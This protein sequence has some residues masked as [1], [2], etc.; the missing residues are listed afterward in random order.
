MSVFRLLATMGL[1]L[2]AVSQVAATDDTM[3]V[4]RRH[5]IHSTLMDEDREYWISLPS[6][7]SDSPDSYRTY[8]VLY[9]TDGEAYLPSVS[10]IV[11]FLS[12]ESVYTFQIPELIIVGLSHP[13]RVR[14]L[15]PTHSLMGQNGQENARFG[16]SGGG[17]LFLEF[18]HEELIPHIDETYRTQPFRILMG[19]SSGGLLA[20]HDLVSDRR[21]FSAHIAIDPSLW[22]D[23]RAT[24]RQAR[25]L[26]ESGWDRHAVVHLSAAAPRPVEGYDVQ[27]HFDAIKDFAGLLADG[28]E[29]QFVSRYEYFPEEEHDTVALPGFSQGLKFV[30]EGY[31]P[32]FYGFMD[33]PSAMATQ[34]EILTRRLGYTMLPPE[35]MVNMLGQLA[36]GGGD[37]EGA[38]VFFRI[39][40]SNY[41]DSFH[42]VEALVGAL[43]ES[44]EAVAEVEL[45]LAHNP[46][47][48]E[49]R[50]LLE[51]MQPGD[52]QGETTV[53]SMDE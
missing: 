51:E 45:F 23:D 38:L 33:N 10:G 8:P 20:L 29:E 37:V 7:Y 48:V 53:K 30:F 39:N 49:G 27:M 43:G 34:Y 41:P 4:G 19:H 31:R 35:G 5:T 17:E 36:A 15:L 9:V 24:L 42:A 26:M 21:S 52:A 1:L 12:S 40:R 50:E 25:A 22:W 47:H 18:I 16:E 2:L 13:N 11:H 44:S 32:D 3:V 46:D 6:S 28:D 14:D